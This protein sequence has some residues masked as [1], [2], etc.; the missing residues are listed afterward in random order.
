MAFLQSLKHY[1]FI[2]VNT[3]DLNTSFPSVEL[4]CTQSTSSCR[5]SDPFQPT[6][7]PP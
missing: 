4:V 1:S 2:A 5:E 3:M 7:F 6:P